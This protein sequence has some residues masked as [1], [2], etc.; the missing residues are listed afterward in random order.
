[1]ATHSAFPTL[2]GAFHDQD[3]YYL[4]MDCGVSF[5]ETSIA[6][7]KVALAY[8]RQLAR[9]L[10]ALHERGIIHSDLKDDNLMLGSDGHLIVIDFGL[11]YVFSG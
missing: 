5:V 4:V 2:H 3:N 10:L 8:G 9:A 6:S 11:A 7:R 1:M